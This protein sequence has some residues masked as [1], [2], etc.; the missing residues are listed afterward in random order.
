MRLFCMKIWLRFLKKPR[1]LK[2]CL[3]FLYKLFQKYFR[4]FLYNYKTKTIIPL[5]KFRNLSTLSQKFYSPKGSFFL[6]H[7]WPEPQTLA[8][9]AFPTMKLLVLVVSRLF[10]YQSLLQGLGYQTRPAALSTAV[11]DRTRPQT[12]P[13]VAF[14]TKRLLVL[15]VSGLF[16]IFKFCRR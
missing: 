15:G 2:F 4:L 14:P 10:L 1:H 5:N 11:R 6:G 13:A 8:S 9:P 3:N 12:P 7:D 16:C